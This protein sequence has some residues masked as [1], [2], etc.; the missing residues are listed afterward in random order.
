MYQLTTAETGCTT[1]PRFPSFSHLW[2]KTNTVCHT[3]AFAQSKKNKKN[4]S[5]GQ[6]YM[7]QEDCRSTLNFMIYAK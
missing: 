3:F 1:G 2:S 4:R 6:D 7:Q 5:L